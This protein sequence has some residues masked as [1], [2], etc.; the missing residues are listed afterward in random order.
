MITINEIPLLLKVHTAFYLLFK[1]KHIV[2][3]LVASYFN[4]SDSLHLNT[5]F[6][7]VIYGPPA[8]CYDTVRDKDSTL[9]IEP[10]S[11]GKY[12]LTE[13]QLK[14]HFTSLVGHRAEIKM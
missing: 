14:F 11:V 6:V 2:C 8:R 1:L 3:S 4:L 5:L 12:S 7:S 10:S 9:R 13:Q